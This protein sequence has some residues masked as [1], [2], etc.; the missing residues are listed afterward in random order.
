[1]DQSYHIPDYCEPEALQG[2]FQIP[3][4]TLAMPKQTTSKVAPKQQ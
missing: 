2:K 1:M 4:L 3:I